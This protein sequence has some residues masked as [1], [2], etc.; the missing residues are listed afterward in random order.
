[1]ERDGR[2]ESGSATGSGIGSVVPVAC[3]QQLP[4]S[5]DGSFHGK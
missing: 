4:P 3:V 5:K 2:D 1:V